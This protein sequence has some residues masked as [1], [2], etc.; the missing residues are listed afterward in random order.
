M[1]NDHKVVIIGSGPSGAMAAHELVS[2]G[3]PVVMLE[4]GDKFPR[5]LLVRLAGKN[6]YRW[7][8]GD[9]FRE[10]DL[11]TS[12][13][14]PHTAWHYNFSPGGMSNDWTGAVPRFAPEDFDEGARLHERYR[15][16]VTYNDLVP[17]YEKS[18]KFLEV[19][20]NPSDVPQ[21]NAGHVAFPHHLPK[22]WQQ[23]AEYAEAVGQGLTT[24]PIADGKPWMI[25]RRG[26]AFNS[27]AKIIVPLLKSKIFTLITNAHVL[28][29]QW[30]G[31]EKRVS[32]VIYY[33][34]TSKSKKRLHADAF[35]V[36]CGPLNSTKL[37]FDSTC[38][39]FPNGLGNSEG[40]LGRYLHDHPKEW[41]SFNTDKPLTVLSPSAY[42]T[43]IPHAES[44]PLLSTSWTLSGTSRKDKL[45]SLFG[46]KGNSLA[47]QIFGTMIPKEA[48]YAR[49]DC[50][51]KD[52]F[53][54]PLLDLHIKYEADVIDNVVKS[55]QRLISIMNA[56][57]YQ[58]TLHEVLPQLHPGQSVHYGGSVR[59]HE[60]A[61]YGV[62]DGANRLHDAP[63]VIVS[64]ASCFTTGSEKNPTLTA[65]ALSA[66]AAS[67][68]V[69]DLKK[70][71][72]CGF[73]WV[74]N[75]LAQCADL[76]ANMV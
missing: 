27:Y 50:H 47:V 41:W 64:D 15:W 30:S 66:R 19:T 2:Q 68:L 9:G 59:M 26:T 5:G 65:M 36:T 75:H 67:L 1:E 11:H 29:L 57:G 52:A 25:A 56:A 73:V 54:L 12:S 46:M 4:S 24:I 60:S 51:K 8:S 10:G 45:K 16:P 7:K 37:L 49:P 43:R 72:L 20:A 76:L 33:D 18:E 28:R 70:G 61:K 31:Q 58:C 44:A 22:D 48:F 42:L 69:A 38:N 6:L 53:G 23:I 35:I 74:V 17:F 32:S 63:N 14:D 34:K 71:I 39:D 40:V 55:R 13:G 62:V 3:I 21:L